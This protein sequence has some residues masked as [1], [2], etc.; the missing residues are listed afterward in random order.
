VLVELGVVEQRTKAVYEVL[1]GVDVVEVAKRYGVCRQ[2]VHTWLK[3]YANEGFSALVDKSSRPDSCPHQM[4][5][6][7]EA[8]V[9]E[10]RRQ[11]PDF[12]PR[13][14]LYWLGREQVD[15]LPGRS[16]IYR[17]LV[18]HR[19]VE[20]R[21]RRRKKEDYIR[22]ERSR[23]MELWQMD[24]V[25]GFYLRGRHRAQVP[26]GHR[27]PQPVLRLGTPHGPGHRPAGL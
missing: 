4:P 8:R 14:I 22:W 1:D 25:G 11:H 5:A 15:P 26:D 20:P 10:M 17:A 16:S 2:T 18:R 27:R 9:V 19:L 21:K 12:G 6:E 7:I 13:T 24:I 23:S 3:K